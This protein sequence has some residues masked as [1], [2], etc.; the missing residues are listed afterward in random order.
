[1]PEIEVI[2]TMGFSCALGHFQRGVPVLVDD[3]DSNVQALVKARYLIPTVKEG[4]D[5][6]VDHAGVDELLGSGVGARRKKPAKKETS[7]QVSNGAGE[8]EPGT[9]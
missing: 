5:D 8:T 7:G 4:T 3:A 9:D 2:P 6:P 1:M